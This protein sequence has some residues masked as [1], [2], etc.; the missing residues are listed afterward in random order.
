MCVY[1]TCE[2]IAVH[3]NEAE[4]R[5]LRDRV[6]E[7]DKHLQVLELPLLQALYSILQ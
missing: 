3:R 6:T 4:A 7:L 1:C 2:Q 5:Q